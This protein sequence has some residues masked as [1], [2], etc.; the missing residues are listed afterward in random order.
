MKTIKNCIFI[1]LL[2]I[3]YLE[4]VFASTNYFD[5]GKKLFNEKK[6]LESKFQFE[7]DIVFNPTNDESY[8]YLAKIHK[9]NNE[10]KFEEQNL[11]AVILLDPKNEEAIYLLTLLKIKKSNF[12]ESENL[13]QTFK[14]ICKNLCKKEEELSTKLK[15][16]QSK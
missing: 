6:F 4:I 3:F 9:H 7:K 16:L 14:K 12:E 1:F 10:D 13:I 5:E 11:K 8:L 15:N 2:N